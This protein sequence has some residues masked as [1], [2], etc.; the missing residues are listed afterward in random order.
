MITIQSGLEL[1][2]NSIQF[3][4]QAEMFFSRHG[5]FP[6]LD[7]FCNLKTNSNKNDF[8]Q[9]IYFII[10]NFFFLIGLYITVRFSVKGT[11]S[12]A[13]QKKDFFKLIL[14]ISVWA[15]YLFQWNHFKCFECCVK[16]AQWALADIWINLGRISKNERSN[17]QT[18]KTWRRH[19]FPFFF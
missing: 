16:V 6:K 2:F 3:G 9:K 5:Q 4:S 8:L 7:R 11:P 12:N 19:P 15:Y 17:K 18:G 14:I 13:R 10:I 1:D